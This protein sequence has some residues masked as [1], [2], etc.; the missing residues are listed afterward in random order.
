[1][2][3]TKS[4]T[5]SEIEY[6]AYGVA[7][8]LME[9]DEP[10]PD[11]GTRFPNIL[12]SCLGQPFIIFSK[13]HLYAG[14][15]G[16]AAILFYLMVKNHPFGNGNKR[17]A[18]ATLLYMLFKNGKWLR[19]SNEALYTF[20]LDVAKSDPKKKDEVILQIEKFI[21]AHLIPNE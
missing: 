21:K 17:I 3:K 16:K 4:I 12:E 11:F 1:M 18:I 15:T 14:L 19:L 13:K 7:K 9:W 8:K 20:A 10:I 2:A 6:V 5:I